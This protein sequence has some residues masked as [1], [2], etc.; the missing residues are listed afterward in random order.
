MGDQPHVL[1]LDLSLTSTGWAIERDGQ[2]QTGT[3]TT[4]N[5]R[6]CA[7]LDRIAR[8]VIGLALQDP[9]VHL[10]ALE[11]YAFGRPNQ[12][13]Q[14]GE[15]GGTVRL[16]LWRRDMPFIEVPP[17]TVKKYAA[18]SGAAKKEQML[19]EA[20]R[21][22]GYQGSSNDVA[23]ALWIRAVVLEAAGHPVTEMPKT[24]V[25]AVHATGSGKKKHPSLTEQV[26]SALRAT[27]TAK[28]RP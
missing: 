17:S 8:I 15:L 1:G 24:H 12:A 14:I 6:D 21:R 22:L 16:E 23:D 26:A 3:I 9:A 28:A 2:V 18:G 20:I 5:L 11:G 13:H 4:G 19:A 7:R 25:A 10:V 27:T